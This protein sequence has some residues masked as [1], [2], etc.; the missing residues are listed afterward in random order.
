MNEYVDAY[1]PSRLIGT[2]DQP[3]GLLTAAIRRQ[4]FSVVLL[5]EIEKGHPG[6]FDLLLAVLGEGRLTDS[7]GRTAD[8]GNAI[9]IMTSNLGSRAGSSAFGL[10]PA[11]ASSRATY[12]AAAENFSGP[13]SSTASTGSCRSSTCRGRRWPASPSG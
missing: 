3:E 5:D 10:R 9:V 4:P 13:S 6:V 7:L 12:T 11:N 8:F 1:S 2:G